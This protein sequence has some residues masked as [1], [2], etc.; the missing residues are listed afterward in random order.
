MTLVST[1]LTS[2]TYSPVFGSSELPFPQGK[3]IDSTSLSQLDHNTSVLWCNYCVFISARLVT[4]N[5]N[6]RNAKR[7]LDL[8]EIARV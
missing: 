4:N 2:F 3:T 1:G 7:M 6:G 8:W 5:F